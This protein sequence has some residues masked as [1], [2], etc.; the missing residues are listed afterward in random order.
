MW[1]PLQDTG[2]GVAF[3]KEFPSGRAPAALARLLNELSSQEYAGKIFAVTS[4]GN[5]RLTTAPDY[6]QADRHDV[7]AIKCRGDEYVVGYIE[8]RSS[9]ASPATI[10]REDE[11]KSVVERYLLRLLLHRAS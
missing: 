8:A 5:L 11:L 6:T 1:R 3:E 9:K 7:V 10:C 4:L 2:L